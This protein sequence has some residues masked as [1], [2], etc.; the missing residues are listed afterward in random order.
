[1]KFTDSSALW[2]Q[3]LLRL[4]PLIN[5]GRIEAMMFVGT[6]RTDTSRQHLRD[7][8]TGRLIEE[9]GGMQ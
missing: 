9:S 7:A 4:P 5:F 8:A 3:C 2:P 1:M 6:V